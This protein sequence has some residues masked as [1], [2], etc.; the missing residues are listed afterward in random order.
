M[1]EDLPEDKGGEEPVGKRSRIRAAVEEFEVDLNHAIVGADDSP[2]SERIYVIED[3]R[4]D[5]YRLIGY[6]VD[7]DGVPESSEV[8]IPDTAVGSIQGLLHAAGMHVVEHLEGEAPVS[9]RDLSEGMGI[10]EP[11]N[12]EPGETHAR[13]K[14]DDAGDQE[15]N[16]G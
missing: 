5:G 12:P 3:V 8:H 7:A 15:G 6:G 1:P 16:Q 14:S 2:E 11:L 4:T 13:F 9:L 10:S